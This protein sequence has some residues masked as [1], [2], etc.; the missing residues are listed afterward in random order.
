V[1]YLRQ[2]VGQL[3]VVLLL[4]TFLTFLL[5]NL[6][7]GGPEV[8]ALG[9]GASDEQIEQFREEQNL[10]DP[11][12]IRYAKWL[13]GVLSGDLGD[14][15]I[16]NV[17]VSELLGDRLTPTLQLM[18]YATVLALAVAVPLGILS[19]Y[20]ADTWFDKSVNTI[21]FGFLSVPN[22]I[23][24]VLLVFLFSIELGWL[25]ATGYEAWS[26]GAYEH[27]RRM[28]LPT[29]AL[30]ASQVA[31]YMRL[32]RTDMIA[33]L[34]EDFIGVARAKGM[35]TRRILLRHALRPSS[36]SL[37]TVAAITVGQLI[38]G[39]IVIER[40]FAI[41]GL[42]SLIIESIFTRDYL[43]V[44]GC[45]VIVAVGFVLVNFIVDILYAVLDPRIRQARALA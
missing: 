15:L 11:L 17:E 45:I 9:I 23:F 8:A 2:K 25:P 21:A 44:Q 24:A 7:P 41:A 3:V 42:G 6:L 4:V 37:L 40:I 28:I 39:T 27:F 31:V 36:F 18:L 14:S 12:L 19:A 16:R 32:L 20:R 10:D 30:A 43:V 5:L 13:G 1:R 29:V 26:E 38:G 34:Q 22:F 35:P 33:T